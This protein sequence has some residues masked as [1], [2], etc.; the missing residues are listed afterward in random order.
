MTTQDEQAG[1]TYV[2]TA[3][4]PLDE[5]TP[6][7]GNAKRGDVDTIRTS[8][9][10][11]GQYRSLV[12]REIPDG[13]LI[14]LAGNHTLQALTA[15]GH[16]TARCEVVLC[17]DA[18]A[19]RINLVDNKAAEL[20]GYDNDALAELLSYMDGDLDGT[21][22]TQD[23]IEALLHYPEDPAA[24][25]DADDAPEPPAE[26]VSKPGDVW[27]LGPHRV[28]CGDS[29]DVTAVEAMLGGDRADCMWTDPPYGVDYVGKT[30][31]ALTIQNDGAAD[32]PELLAGAFATA[33]VA[34][35]PGAPIYIAHPPGPLSLDFAR[36]F[37]EAGWLLRQNLI[38]VKDSM[39]LGR[40][41]YHYRHEPILYGFTDPS[42]DSGRLGRGGDRWFGDNA[43]T[44]VLEVPKPGRS[45]DHPTMK[46]VELITRCLA[47]S[48]P[49]GGLVYEPFGGSGSTLIA[50]HTTGRVARVCEL[51]PRY[52]DVICRRYQEHTGTKPVLA[53]TGEAHDFTTPPADSDD[54]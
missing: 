16:Q 32:L 33:T 25:N 37:L 46:P 28:L 53:S 54:Q 34:L 3:D 35:K 22:Y 43:Q 2:R 8:L 42:A 19:R 38:W 49:P 13:P 41:D 24:L 5:L 26:P 15:E 51:D 11:N 7:P 14:V 45:K 40:S 10:R 36:A 47:N 17:D 27:I 52:V 48:C 20:G 30:K 29:T 23:D 12:V 39:V 9:R 1:V 18:T 6:F 4:I 44:S 50:A 21:G 31:D